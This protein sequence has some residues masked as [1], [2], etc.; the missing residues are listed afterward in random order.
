VVRYDIEKRSAL[1]EKLIKGEISK[2]EYKKELEI[3]ENEYKKDLIKKKTQALALS[4]IS[5]FEILITGVFFCKS[6]DSGL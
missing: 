6:M 5:N 2:D 3:I 1:D 4:E